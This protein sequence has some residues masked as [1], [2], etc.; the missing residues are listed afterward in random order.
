MATPNSPHDG[1]GGDPAPITSRRSCPACGLPFRDGDDT[2]EVAEQVFHPSCVEP[3]ASD[4]GRRHVGSTLA[5][6][7]KAIGRAS[8]P[9]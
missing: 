4:P 3:E 8:G 7:S 2:V 6:W 5:E 9:A 1:P